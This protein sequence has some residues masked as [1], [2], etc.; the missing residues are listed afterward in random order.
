M[1]VVKE[2]RKRQKRGANDAGDFPEEL[3]DP[4]NKKRR[5][6]LD[7][8]GPIQVK[9]LTKSKKRLGKDAKY[10]A[11]GAKR[12]KK[13]NDAE[14]AADMGGFSRRKN[15]AGPRGGVA[16]SGGFS[17]TPQRKTGGGFGN[18]PKKVASRRPGKNARKSGGS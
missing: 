12:F 4:K 3:L 1:A 15:A 2:W 13:T 10:G 11:G 14:S 18:R 8:A 6:L 5:E 16:Q 17:K 9:G 7:A